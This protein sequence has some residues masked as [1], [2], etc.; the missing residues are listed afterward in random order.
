MAGCSEV[1][2]PKNFGLRSALAINGIALIA[3]GLAIPL[4]LRDNRGRIKVDLSPRIDGSLPAS[5]GTKPVA[6]APLL[7]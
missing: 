1:F 3:I 5:K 7:L 6:R 2:L 4:L